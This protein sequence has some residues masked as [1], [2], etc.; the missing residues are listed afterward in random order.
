[1]AKIL[2]VEDNEDNAFMLSTLLRRLEHEVVIAKNGRDGVE[3][4]KAE[5]PDIIFMDIDLP[6]M[7]GF[8]ATK[9]LKADEATK[10]TILKPSP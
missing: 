3:A 1:M 8:E 10:Q 4:A 6:V 2:Y 7:D 5:M 9:I